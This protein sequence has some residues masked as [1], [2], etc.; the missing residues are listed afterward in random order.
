MRQGSC[1]R[2]LPN[3]HSTLTRLV[4]V[5][6]AMGLAAP[7]RAQSVMN[8]T[9]AAFQASPDHNA[10]LPDNSP[11]V[12]Y[13]Q[14]QFYL[15]GAVSPFQTLTLGKPTPDGTG[16]ITVNFLTLL[17]ASLPAGQIYTA[18][19]AAVGPGGLGTSAMSDNTFA[20]SA[21]CSFSVSPTNLNVAVG[22]GAS[23][24]AVAAGASCGWTATSGTSWLTVTNGASGSGNGTVSVTATANTTTAARNATLT[25][26]GQAVTITQ[27]GITCAFT[28][29][30]TTLSIVAGGGSAPVAVTAAAGCGWTA[31]S[32]ASWLTVTSGGSGSGNGTVSVTAAGNTTTGSRTATLT[33]GGMTVTVTQSAP[34]PAP[35][36]APA[37]LHITTG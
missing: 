34:A 33:V 7:L 29:S 32:T 37:G 18:N 15:L 20:Y 26:A 8:P 14:L 22:G 21:P 4:V 16:T 25:V 23:N 13:Y 36:A 27:P 3:M 11:V 28:V 31:T 10:T 17:G 12:S 19:V 1:K 30:P 6:I 35:P 2:A 9:T 5:L 24:I